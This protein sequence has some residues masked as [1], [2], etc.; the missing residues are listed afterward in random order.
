MEYPFNDNF[1]LNKISFK[2]NVKIHN[3][4]ISDKTKN[5]LIESI[6]KD[7]ENYLNKN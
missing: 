4:N 2:E 3:P 1:F 5:S 7:V 6:K